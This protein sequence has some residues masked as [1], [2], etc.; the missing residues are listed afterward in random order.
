M[1]DHKHLVG[2]STTDLLAIPSSMQWVQDYGSD[3]CFVVKYLEIACRSM[4]WEM[5]LVLGNITSLTK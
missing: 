5:R 2:V 4:P 3:W 1:A